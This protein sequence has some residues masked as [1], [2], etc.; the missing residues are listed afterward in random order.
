MHGRAVCHVEYVETISARRAVYKHK[1][2]PL[3][4]N[5]QPLYVNFAV[6]VVQTGK[7]SNALWVSGIDTSSRVDLQE[8]KDLFEQFGDVENIVLSASYCYTAYITSFY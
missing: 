8:L 4:L 3:Q 5:D 6:D 2:F 7:P 1:S